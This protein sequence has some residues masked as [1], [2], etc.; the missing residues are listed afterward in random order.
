MEDVSEELHIQL[1]SSPNKPNTFQSWSKDSVLFNQATSQTQ[2]LLKFPELCFDY[3]TEEE[4]QTHMKPILSI[5]KFTPI[6]ESVSLN[7][8]LGMGMTNSTNKKPNEK[9]NNIWKKILKTVHE[10]APVSLKEIYQNCDVNHFQ[11]RKILETMEKQDMIE[12]RSVCF[13]SRGNPKT[14]VVLKPNGAAFIGIDF[15]KVRLIGKGSTEHIILQ[16]LIAQAMKDTGKNV[17]IEHY[18]NGKSVDIAE[19]GEKKSIAYE[20][21]LSPSH[22]HVIDN[23]R[24]DFDAGFSKIVVITQNKAGME[25]ARKQVI[26]E[27]DFEKLS[28]VEFKLPKDFL[29]VRK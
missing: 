29:L 26:L 5:L 3:V 18:I 25:E 22:P 8:D 12:S 10:K 1:T 11:G 15:E 20:I 27:I 23:I 13:G 19:I 7:T 6:E 24:K 28:K 4:I 17:L 21:E 2:F 14:Y 16:H 9:P